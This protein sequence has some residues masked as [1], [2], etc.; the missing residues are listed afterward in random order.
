[1]II[2]VQ[3][4]WN[5]LE[6]KKYKTIA[7]EFSISSQAAKKYIEMSDDD[8]KALDNL[9]KYKKRKTVTDDYI[10]IVYK[11]LKD[12]ISPEIIFSYCIF[13]GYKGN[14]QNL[15]NRIKRMLR[16]NFD[17]LLAQGW[18]YNMDYPKD[19]II[20][21]R[22][23]IIKFIT[24]RNDKI[25]KNK[26][27]EENIDI[28]KEKYPVI[29]EL[30]KIY[31]LFYDTI[32]GDDPDNLD[33]FIETYKESSVKCFVEGIKKDIAPVKNAISFEISSGFVEGNNNKFKL[34]KRILYGRS[35]LVNLFRKCYIPFLMNNID[36]KL[37]DLLQ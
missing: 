2:E 18:Y 25:K 5:D 32:M 11:M 6:K 24:A 21:K 28:L 31:A 22:N 30:D 36:F 27:I 12:K 17:I 26:K 1:M 34:L 9:T 37:N 3:K 8:I 7:Q 33:T 14:Y 10:N 19:I 4:R 35:G 16:N 29:D 23:D 15:E 20:I 13:K